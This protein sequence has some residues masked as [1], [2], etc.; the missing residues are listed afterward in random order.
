MPLTAMFALRSPHFLP[1]EKLQ[2]SHKPP[3][4]PAWHIRL[5][6]VKR[7]RQ[8]WFR[9]FLL[10]LDEPYGRRGVSLAALVADR[11]Q[12]VCYL[13]A[14]A[15]LKTAGGYPKQERQSPAQFWQEGRDHS[16]WSLAH[17]CWCRSVNVRNV[18]AVPLEDVL[19]EALVIPEPLPVGRV[20][21]V[22]GQNWASSCGNPICRSCK[23]E[24]G[25]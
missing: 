19:A 2:P 14:A 21:H 22:Y 10:C 6:I 9:G 20:V 25:V 16:Q 12:V 5:P 24:G 15:A 23:H 7:R 17:S 3:Q 1:A 13:T 8:D 18:R 11:R 4:L